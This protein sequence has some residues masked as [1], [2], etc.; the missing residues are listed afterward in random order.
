MGGRGRWKGTGSWG[1]DVLGGGGVVGGERVVGGEEWGGCREGEK[2][3]SKVN[4]GGWVVV[5][6]LS[7]L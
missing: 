2:Q 3:Q 6:A 5:V 4:V 1:E 7:N